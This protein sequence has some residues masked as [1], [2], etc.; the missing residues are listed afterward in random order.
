MSLPICFQLF[1][2]QAETLFCEI[3]TVYLGNW[4]DQALKNEL[5]CQSWGWIFQPS[6]WNLYTCQFSGKLA[7]DL[8]LVFHTWKTTQAHR[9]S[10]IFLWSFLRSVHLP[11]A[12]QGTCQHQI[13][14]LWQATIL[15]HHVPT[16]VGCGFEKSLST[17]PYSHT[18]GEVE[19]PKGGPS[20]QNW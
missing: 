14:V 4:Q 10:P 17:H 3:K 8:W 9:Y 18:L 7:S 16:L 5:H 11:Q 12:A 6:C 1:W 20:V 15:D 19:V 13:S 2:R